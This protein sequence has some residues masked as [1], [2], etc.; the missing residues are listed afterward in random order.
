MSPSVTSA[1]VRSLA[2]PHLLFEVADT[3]QLPSSK[4]T[5]LLALPLIAVRLAIWSVSIS[6]DGRGNV[7]T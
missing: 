6:W 4:E 7:V 2:A 5:T 1:K 3:S